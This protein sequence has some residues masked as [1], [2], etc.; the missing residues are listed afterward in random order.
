MYAAVSDINYIAESDVFWKKE[1]G[2]VAK[3]WAFKYPIVIYILAEAA[4]ASFHCYGA[5]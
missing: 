4:S 5:L 2:S 1:S 3:L